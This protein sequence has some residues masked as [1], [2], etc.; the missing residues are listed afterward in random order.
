MKFQG[1]FV[2]LCVFVLRALMFVQMMFFFK[3]LDIW[4]IANGKNKAVFTLRV[5]IVLLGDRQ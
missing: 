4:N 3:D 5:Y 2:A 1:C